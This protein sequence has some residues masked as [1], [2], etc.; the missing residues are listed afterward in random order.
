M[1][2]LIP[3]RG[4]HHHCACWHRDASGNSRLHRVHHRLPQRAALGRQRSREGRA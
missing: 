1:M 3:L 4:L 2:K